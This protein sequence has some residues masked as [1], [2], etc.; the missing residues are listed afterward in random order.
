MALCSAMTGTIAVHRSRS[1]LAGVHSY[2]PHLFVFDHRHS[3]RRNNRYARCRNL[4]PW[5]P[6]LSIRLCQC[7]RGKEPLI[8]LLR[9]FVASFPSLLASQGVFFLLSRFVLPP[10]CNSNLQTT[11]RNLLCVCPCSAMC[12]VF[13]SLCFLAP[14]PSS[15]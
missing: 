11:C 6:R 15:K 9:C 10:I 3:D 12:V 14:V 8:G 2:S 7:A 4:S 1:T 13:P 5:R